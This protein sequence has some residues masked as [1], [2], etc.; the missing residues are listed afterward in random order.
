MGPQPVNR[1]ET[2]AAGASIDR[3]RDSI[4]TMLGGMASCQINALKMISV[5]STRTPHIRDK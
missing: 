2:P 4:S 1:R 5:R 3:P